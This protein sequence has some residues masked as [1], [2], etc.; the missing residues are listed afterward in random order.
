MNKGL[1]ASLKEVVPKKIWPLLRWLDKQL[2][3]GMY[4]WLWVKRK[5]V[6]PIIPVRTGSFVAQSIDSF[7][8]SVE[9]QDVGLEAI[10]LQLKA[11]GKN[12]LEGRH[13]VYLHDIHDIK[14]FCPD[15]LG[16]YPGGFGLKIIKSQIMS[17]DSTPYYTSSKNA[18]A[19]TWFSMRAVGTMLEK[20]TVSNLLYME[21]VAP[22]VYDIVRLTTNKNDVFYAFVVQHIPGPAL[23]GSA[24]GNFMMTFKA[25]LKTNGME[26]ISIKEHRDLRG[27]EYNLNIASGEDSA[28]YV[29]IQ[30]FVL[31]EQNIV[32]KHKNDIREYSFSLETYFNMFDSLEEENI[33]VKDQKIL[34]LGKYSAGFLPHALASGAR[35]CTVD[36]PEEEDLEKYEKAFY[37]YGLSRFELFGLDKGFSQ[38]VRGLLCSSFDMICLD[39][40][41]L[42]R[43][44]KTLRQLSSPTYVICFSDKKE[45][46]LTALRH[47]VEEYLLEEKCQIKVLCLEKG[48]THNSLPKVGCS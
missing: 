37:L 5:L 31:A 2:V 44:K 35:W 36:L 23:T 20:M 15:L 13:S 42:P 27:P 4:V 22:Q 6:Y 7:P 47:I 40:S 28:C 12:I 26:T 14:Q 18:P 25:A 46:E 43:L 11:Q 33:S 1:R 21:G 45:H 29:D 16:K 24:A 10:L 17:K 8:L 48:I 34:L 32:D 19:S 9:Y 41:S 39:D 38:D 30:N 3:Y